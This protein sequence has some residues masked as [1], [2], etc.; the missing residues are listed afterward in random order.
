MFPP[1]SL[2][3]Q[4]T[5]AEEVERLCLAVWGRP[6]MTLRAEVDEA[7]LVRMQLEAEPT[8]PFPQHIHDPLGVV[9]GLEGHHEI[10]S[11]PYQG[12]LPPHAW[13]HLVL[14]PFV[15]HMVQENVREHW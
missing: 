1:F 12:R 10:I 3:L 14:E 2:S 9:V 8:K 15:Q 7:R 11:E 5:E 4:H 6:A 13:S